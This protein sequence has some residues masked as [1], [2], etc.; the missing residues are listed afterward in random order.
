[1]T[2]P[3]SPSLR[4]LPMAV[5]GAFGL[6]A[7]E[8]DPPSNPPSGQ[9]MPAM[10]VE[11]SRYKEEKAV[12]EVDMT[13]D[14]RDLPLEVKLRFGSFGDANWG[15][16]KSV[17]TPSRVMQK[18]KNSSPAV[19][20]LITKDLKNAPALS[21]DRALAQALPEFSLSSRN[22]SLS[23]PGFL[24]G[25]AL[26][27]IGA[28]GGGT[29]VLLDGA[30][31]NDPWGNLPRW[32]DVPRTGLIRA[33]SVPAGGAPSW[34]EGAGGGV[35]QLIST[36]PSGRMRT[37]FRPMASKSQPNPRSLTPSRPTAQTQDG[38]FRQPT[39]VGQITRSLVSSY[40]TTALIADDGTRRMDITWEQRK[41]TGIAQ[42]TGTAFSSDGFSPLSAG[43][44]GAIDGRTWSRGHRLSAR[45][46]QPVFRSAELLGTVRITEDLRSE[47]TPYQQ[48][49]ATG[50]FASLALTDAPYGVPTW[51]GVAYVHAQRSHQRW[52]WVDATRTTE[53]P[54]VDQFAMPSVALGALWGGAWWNGGDARTMA[55]ADVRLVQ[56]ELRE[57]REFTNGAFQKVRNA[58]GNQGILGAYVSHNRGLTPRLRASVGARLDAWRDGHAFRRESSR[59][60]AGVRSDERFPFQSGLETS[61]G[62][63]L[64]W[65]AT[66]EV[67]LRISG[68]QG[69]RR[70]SLQE[71]FQDLGYNSRFILADPFLRRERVTSI[72]V[73]T[74]WNATRRL[75]LDTAVFANQRH[76]ALSVRRLPATS[77]VPRLL[78]GAPSGY[79][80]WTR[81][82]VDRM[83]GH[84]AKL[85]GKWTLSPRL[86]L[87]ATMLWNNVTLDRLASAPELQGRTPPQVARRV[88]TLGAVWSTR[89]RYEFRLNVRAFGPQFVDTENT[90]TL[91]GAAVTDIGMNVRLARR[92]QLT[93]TG[94]NVG[95]ARVRTDE[96]SSGLVTFGA[97]R[98]L[99]AAL[100]IDWP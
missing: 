57:H 4:V 50:T 100:R 71:R 24:Q 74:S 41:E 65:H 54:V 32:S 62:A 84:G 52:S 26:R 30:P 20:L 27:G 77:Q 51:T 25:A 61:A 59:D 40:E 5:V 87:E 49:G 16:F 58:G 99:A 92:V 17:F 90:R 79:E 55:G 39:A 7:Q 82:N 35:I 85:S 38:S 93:L 68:Q 78:D 67:H 63:G 37:Q 53:T 45:W 3:R 88:A 11:A 83:E 2:R 10:I 31:L 75:E 18:E 22:D 86:A 21:I 34:G 81:T 70:P 29:L 12:P 46:R 19:A 28:L 72:E 8:P 73:S 64:V 89:V 98:R 80:V 13:I 6:Q 14:R 33:E 94:E 23:S 36:P 42:I 44:R 56:G 15:D 48:T 43:Q 66:D 9:A 69:F 96:S 97:P 60:P 1:M 95:N 76:H 91:E 47:G